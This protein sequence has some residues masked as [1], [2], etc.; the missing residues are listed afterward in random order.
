M[1]TNTPLENK[2]LPTTD[3]RLENN[4]SSQ[5]ISKNLLTAAKPKPHY[6]QK[7]Q[8]KIATML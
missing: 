7:Q 5:M 2:V 6:V 1:S 3:Q 8:I 4:Q